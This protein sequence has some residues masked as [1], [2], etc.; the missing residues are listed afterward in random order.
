MPPRST[1]EAPLLHSAGP[2]GYLQITRITHHEE[3]RHKSRGG[4]LRARSAAALWLH[5]RQ[6]CGATTERRPPAGQALGRRSRARSQGHHFSSWVD[7]YS[8]PSHWK[9]IS[10]SPLM[11]LS[12][13]PLN[14]QTLCSR[15]SLRAD[16]L[17]R[18]VRQRQ[19]AT[20]ST[21]RADKLSWRPAKR[22]TAALSP[23]SN[24]GAQQGGCSNQCSSIDDRFIFHAYIHTA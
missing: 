18:S 17:G 3:Q 8:G 13:R 10:R 5:L 24:G 16:S 12:A 21:P 2:R 19:R 22:H 1:H 6:T 4:D 9:F 14:K 20:I 11:M 23:S 7:S 15:H